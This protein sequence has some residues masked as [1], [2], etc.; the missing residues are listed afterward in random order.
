MMITMTRTG[1]RPPEHNKPRFI[2][3]TDLRFRY[4]EKRSRTQIRRDVAA[5]LYP[6]PKQISA[7]RIA[8]EIAELD[9]HYD[10]LSVV[11]YA[12]EV[13]AR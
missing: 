2:A 3:Y 6:P 11:S 1:S 4:G 9:T 13:A 5:G 8:W 12:D 10:N 7:G